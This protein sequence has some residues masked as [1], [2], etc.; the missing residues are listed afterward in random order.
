MQTSNLSKTVVLS[1]FEKL[2]IAF[3]IGDIAAVVG[4]Y[5]EALA[6][7]S[8]DRFQAVCR[9]LLRE[10]ESPFLPQPAWFIRRAI[11]IAQ[12]EPSRSKAL[13]FA[14]PTDTPA[15]CPPH[16]R[17]WMQ[18]QVEPIREARSNLIAARRS[19]F[20]RLHAEH[21]M[22]TGKRLEV[23]TPAM[24][25]AVERDP[26]VAEARGF[27]TGAADYRSEMAA[28]AQSMTPEEE[29]EFTYEFTMPDMD[30]MPEEVEF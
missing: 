13:P 14:E 6:N 1:E 3:R 27:G 10:W 17:K 7:L 11:E 22:L 25:D 5:H 19:A 29:A 2:A 12:N 20:S 26:K 15:V 8:N 18:L 23:A 24:M 9:D 28:I 21:M 30:G 16:V 4:L